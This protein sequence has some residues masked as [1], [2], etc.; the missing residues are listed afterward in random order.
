MLIDGESLD[1]LYV[2]PDWQGLG[3]GSALLAKA[4]TV[5]PRRLV[6]WTFQRNQRARAFYESRGFR[7]I[8]QTEGENEENE[9]DVQYEWR[10][11]T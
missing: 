5:S 8:A 9:P 2:A 6:L 3:F 1:H 11:P 10:N 4:K 7:S